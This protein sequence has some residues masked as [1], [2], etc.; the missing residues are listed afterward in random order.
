MKQT[1]PEFVRASRGARTFPGVT[2]ENY[3][4]RR[5]EAAYQMAARSPR[6]GRAGRVLDVGCGEGY[7]PAILRAAGARVDAVELDPATAE[8]AARTYP[9]IRVVRADAC[10]L[11]YRGGTFDAIVALQVLEHLF[12]ADG[13][14]RRARELLKAGGTLVLSTPNRETFSPNGVPNDFHAYE[15]TAEEL[16][17]ILRVHFDNITVGGLHHGTKLAALDRLT[18]TPIQQRLMRTPYAELPRSLRLALHSVRA[19]DFRVGPP[20]GSLDLL[21]TGYSA[22]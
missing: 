12:C 13:F 1:D 10:S 14:L 22:V 6:A 4:F 3:W 20:E 18:R 16:E 17:A 11:P 9:E 5:H 7:G 2:E 21:A 19:H 15:Y 8:H